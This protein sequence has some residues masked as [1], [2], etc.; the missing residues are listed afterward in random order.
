MS[1]GVAGDYVQQCQRR[2]CRRR[3]DRRRAPSSMPP[4]SVPPSSAPPQ[5]AVER[6]AVE[7]AAYER[8]A[9]SG[10]GVAGDGRAA[11]PLLFCSSAAVE[12]AAVERTAAERRRACS[13]RACRRRAC[14]RNFNFC[15]FAISIHDC[16]IAQTTP[17]TG[18]FCDGPQNEGNGLIHS[19]ILGRNQ[20]HIGPWGV[21]GLK[22][23]RPARSTVENLGRRIAPAKI[24]IQTWSV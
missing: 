14:R 15:A 7:C 16:A 8:A 6:A 17:R 19:H 12:R 11:G 18:R 21:L 13:R 20:R 4:S 24:C 1:F 22:I 9:I 2:T 23:V 10:E 3:A 5:S